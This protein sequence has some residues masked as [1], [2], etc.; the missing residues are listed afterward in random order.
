MRWQI[1]SERLER[2]PETE[3]LGRLAAAMSAL[4]SD[5]CLDADEVF[6]AFERV[7][8]VAALTRTNS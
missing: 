8:E 7:A 5:G 3:L 6:D 4:E 2:T 1:L